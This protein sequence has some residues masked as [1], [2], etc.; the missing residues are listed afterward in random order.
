MK[1]FPE[2]LHFESAAQP[3][4]LEQPSSRFAKASLACAILLMA[5][6]YTFGEWVFHPGLK[7][8]KQWAFWPD[9]IWYAALPLA[10]WLGWKIISLGKLKV[11]RILFMTAILLCVGDAFFYMIP[12]ILES[13][14]RLHFHEFKTP[15]EKWPWTSYW[16]V[17]T[18]WMPTVFVI[19]NLVLLRRWWHLFGSQFSFWR[20]KATN[21]K[22]AWNSLKKMGCGMV[23]GYFFGRPMP[24][25]AFYEWLT[26]KGEEQTL[27]EH[28]A[29]PQRRLRLAQ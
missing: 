11:S 13:L 21:G 1:K 20:S 9:L 25:D 29:T 16:Y 2:W 12:S 5:V 17:W 28:P 22:A 19:W 6:H 4:G 24:P 26:Q 15:V 7:L 23:Q 18:F 3:N 27:T 8:W 14:Q 10:L